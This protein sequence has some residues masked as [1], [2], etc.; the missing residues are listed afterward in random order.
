[1]FPDDQLVRE[2]AKIIRGVID[3][4]ARVR[5]LEYQRLTLEMG[6]GGDG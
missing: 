2:N 6:A 1:M 3:N 5:E 4:V